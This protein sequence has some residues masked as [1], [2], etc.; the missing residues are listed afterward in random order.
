MSYEGTISVKD[1]GAVGDGIT[2]DSAAFLAAQNAWVSSRRVNLAPL[3][4]SNKIGTLDIYVPPG[5]YLITNPQAMLASTVSGRTQGMVWR[6][7]PGGQS[8]ILFQPAT[9][10]YLF[11]NN[12]AVLGLRLIDLWF[13]GNSSSAGFMH[14]TSNGG[15]QDYVFERCY[16]D[17]T[18]NFGLFLDGNNTNSEFQ[19]NKC[20]LSGAIAAFIDASS[21][22]QFVN[23][24]FTN[25]S[26]DSLSGVFL[27]F[28]KG[29]NIK[30]TDCDFSGYG[31]GETVT[32][33]SLLG[34]THGQGVCSFNCSGSRFEIGAN[35]TV[36]YSEWGFGQ[37]K[38]D[39]CDM[40]SQASQSW[41][42]TCVPIQF[43]WGNNGGPNVLFKNCLLMGLHQYIVGGNAWSE[44]KAVAYENCDTA[45]F[46]DFYSMF[47]TSLSSGSITTY[48]PIAIRDDCRGTQ[49]ISLY[50]NTLTAQSTLWA[51]NT[52]YSLNQI[53]AAGN[54]SGGAF[55]DW[56]CYQ[57]TTPGTSGTVTP[58]GP[59]NVNDNTVVWK[60]I[61]GNF[62]FDFITE[63]SVNAGSTTQRLVKGE[64]TAIFTFA[65]TNGLGSRS[66]S[67][68][69]GYAKMVF[70][71]NAVVT[72][73]EIYY[74]N[75]ASSQTGTASWRMFQDG[76][77]GVAFTFFSFT[78]NA[79][80][81]GFREVWDGNRALGT[82][83]QGRTVVLEA[84]LDVSA[85]V[86]PPA[87]AF[88][89]YICGE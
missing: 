20:Y 46:I 15:A 72:H 51:A 37:I 74:P 4:N 31:G 56:W 87:I 11:Y 49:S 22:D 41:S 60:A 78:N 9:S 5:S 75:G 89:R 73:A 50:D 52:A 23:Y 86:A 61:G 64:R 33:F 13:N 27:S 35:C 10:G 62:T 76:A 82:T 70:P 30:V 55:N 59:G 14:S 69:K 40:S 57:C 21:S 68:V 81:T 53:V 28:T 65:N 45:S 2:D 47:E 77:S 18:W 8:Q 6:G 39:G 84:G 3:A 19:F 36:L 17:G 67:T 16:F 48:P 63:G 32:L 25:C 80:S 44:K 26:I 34:N 88:I 24:F 38:F 58:F 54:A 85:N 42:Q 83:L 66:S 7:V 71:P 43:N 29:G 1:F 79:P 12:D